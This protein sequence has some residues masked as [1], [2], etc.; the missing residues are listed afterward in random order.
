M[1]AANIPVVPIGEELAGKRPVKAIRFTAAAVFAAL[2]VFT[3]SGLR[4]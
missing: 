4:L 3:L 2:G 1:V